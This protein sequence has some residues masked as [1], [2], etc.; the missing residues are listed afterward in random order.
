M[1]IAI[2]YIIIYNAGGRRDRLRA[3]LGVLGGAGRRC[4]PGRSWRRSCVPAASGARCGRSP[5]RLAFDP[6]DRRQ[7][8]RRAWLIWKASG[9]KAGGRRDRRRDLA[10]S[11]GIISGRRRRTVGAF[12]ASGLAR[13]RPRD[14]CR[15]AV[16]AF[17]RSDF[18]GR[19]LSVP[20]NFSGGFS[21]PFDFSGAEISFS[22]FSCLPFS[23]PHHFRGV[24]KMLCC[25]NFAT[26]LAIHCKLA[27]L[28]VT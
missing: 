7:L 15:A 5:E 26:K 10:S 12:S 9:I 22:A 2:I 28:R 17:S 20:Q 4:Y 14:F 16:G 21:V 27:Y 8:R 3:F 13:S 6:A 11:A 1:Y 19:A 18:S 24:T 23:R 25:K